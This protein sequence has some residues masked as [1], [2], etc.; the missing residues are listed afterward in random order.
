[1]N[2]ERAAVLVDLPT[3][4]RGFCFHDDDG[5]PYI[6]LNARLTREANQQTYDH[7]QRHI[8][9]GDMENT[10]YTE[11]GEENSHESAVIDPD[12]HHY[13][14]G[15]RMGRAKRKALCPDRGAGEGRR[16]SEKE[17]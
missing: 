7:E 11:Y 9:R 13:Y 17:G 4:V 5:E 16:G 8:E 1:M 6:V 14:L 12:C 2:E 10:L 15:S 3:S